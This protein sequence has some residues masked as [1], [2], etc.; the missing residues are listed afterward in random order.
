[1]NHFWDIYEDLDEIVY[2]SDMDTYEIIYLNRKTRE[3]FGIKDI[4]ET[5][6]L[7][8]YE[9]FQHNAAPCAMCTNSRLKKN[10]TYE[11]SYYNTLIEKIFT[12]R[13]SMTEYEGRRLRIETAIAQTTNHTHDTKGPAKMALL[14]NESMRMAM[15]ENNPENGIAALLEYLGKSLRSD[16]S[17]IFEILEKKRKT[18]ME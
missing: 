12:L 9:F 3:M 14:V 4:S 8:C 10:E 16:R 7:K 6:G 18:G 5:N 17:Y 15:E 13:D 11:W 2:I 1:M